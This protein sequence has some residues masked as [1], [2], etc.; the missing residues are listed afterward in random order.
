MGFFEQAMHLPQERV[1]EFA[2]RGSPQVPKGFVQLSLNI[3]KFTLC[4]FSTITRKVFT[5]K[6]NVGGPSTEEF[7]QH[8]GRRNEHILSRYS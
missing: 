2:V 3:I 7:L 6:R 5:L 8:F 4:H 1:F